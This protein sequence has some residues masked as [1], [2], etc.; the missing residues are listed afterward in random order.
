MNH[1]SAQPAARPKIIGVAHIALNVSDVGR[2]RTFYKDFLGYG[3]PYHLDK[4]DGSLALTFI[5]VT[6]RQYIEL[7]PGLRPDQD[8][9]NH[10]AFYVEDAEAMRAYLAARGVAVPDR[11]RRTRIGTI[12]FSVKD[13]EGHTVEM[14]QD[15]PDSWAA[16]EKGNF[17]A[18]DRVSNRMPHVGF[19]AGDLPEAMK[20]YGDILGFEEFWRGADR[21]GETLSWVNIRLPDSNDYVELMLYGEKPAPDQRGLENHLCLELPDMAAAVAHL[22]QRP[23]RKEYSREIGIRVGVNRK[24]QVNLYDPDGTRVELME[25]K[26]IDGIPAPS[27]TR[28]L[29]V[30][31]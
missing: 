31:K 15:Q 17:I 19:L 29:P 12:D 8:R 26:T 21:N 7:Y 11:V 3:E 1:P 23:C 4:E 18:D 16:R 27:S 30:R 22:E 28:P 2:S 10:I 20:F 5:K 9:L 13:P 25:S 6:E 14:V 24:R